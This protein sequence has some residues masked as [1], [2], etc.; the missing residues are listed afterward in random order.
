M[1]NKPGVA[2]DAARHRLVV[3]GGTYNL[4]PG[5]PRPA[6]TPLYGDT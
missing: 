4:P 1:R 6:T 2:Y 3:F 5:S